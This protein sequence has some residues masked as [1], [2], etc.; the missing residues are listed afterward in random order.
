[1][2]NKQDSKLKYYG[3]LVVVLGLLAT[4]ISIPF[5]V[6]TTPTL[7]QLDDNSTINMKLDKG[8]QVLNLEVARSD[9]KVLQGLMNRTSLSE[10][11]GMFFIFQEL[12]YRTFWMKNTL[13]SL[14]II[15]L[16]SNFS[17]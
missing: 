8:D 4:I 2:N 15:F 11:K 9:Q 10:N 12:G 1:M 13:I 16:D 5:L 17:K 7:S 3:I 6:S 14:D